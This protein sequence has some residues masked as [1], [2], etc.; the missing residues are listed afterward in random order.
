M[1]YLYTKRVIRTLEL[2]RRNGDSKVGDSFP[3]NGVACSK[4][5]ELT[6]CNVEWV[7][8]CA[9]LPKTR[10]TLA[11]CS[12]LQALTRSLHFPHPAKGASPPGRSVVDGSC[13]DERTRDIPQCVP[14]SLISTGKP[15]T[16]IQVVHAFRPRCLNS[17]TPD[18]HRAGPLHPIAGL[19][20]VM[21]CPSLYSKLRTSPLD[22][23]LEQ[24][25]TCSLQLLDAPGKVSFL[26][27]ARPIRK[28]RTPLA[29]DLAQNRS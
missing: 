29:L 8:A 10:L 2:A 21:R 16:G 3:Y 9:I 19:A 22:T 4:A 23:G 24:G 12:P 28:A 17:L 14:R 15:T 11:R 27:T 13:R 18:A 5:T 6:Y 7:T 20:E 1:P 25:Y 26:H